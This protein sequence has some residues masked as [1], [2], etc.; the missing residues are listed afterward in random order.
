MEVQIVSTTKNVPQGC[1]R[2]QEKY[3][4]LPKVRLGP[5]SRLQSQLVK[6][7]KMFHSH[8]FPQKHKVSFKLCRQEDGEATGAILPHHVLLSS[9][10]YLYCYIHLA[11]T[12]H[13]IQ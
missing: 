4:L 6:R 7:L 9:H 12:I 13:V 2:I 10:Q 8:P 1:G 11:I 5:D 3:F